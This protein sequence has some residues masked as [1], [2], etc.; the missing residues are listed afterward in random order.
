MLSP[1]LIK[2]N[3][4]LFSIGLISCTSVTPFQSYFVLCFLNRTA[5]HLSTQTTETIREIQL[6][7]DKLFLEDL[8]VLEV[9]LLH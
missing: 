2:L 1:T 7:S 8:M 9:L 6:L 5:K 4:L 3:Q